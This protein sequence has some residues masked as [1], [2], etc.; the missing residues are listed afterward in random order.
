V[1]RALAAARHLQEEAPNAAPNRL[2]DILVQEGLLSPGD[3]ARALSEQERTGASLGRV[4]IG[5]GLVTEAGL[6]AALATQLGLEFVAVADTPLN[7]ALVALVPEPM[8]RRY[9]VIPVGEDE[10]GRLKVAMSDPSNILAL[11]DLR[12]VTDREVV[13]VVG[14]RSDILAAIDRYGGGTVEEADDLSQVLGGDEIDIG[15]AIND[16]IDDAPIVRFV[17]ALITRAVRDRAS[18]IHIEPQERDV[19]IRYRVDGVLHD[20]LSQPRKAHAGIASRLKIMADLDIAERRIPQDGRIALKLEG[21]SID[22]RVSTLPTVYGEKIVMRVLDK[23]SVL[24][25]LSDLGFMEHNYGRFEHSFRKPYGMILVTGPTGSGKST[26]LYATLNVINAPE[27]NIVTVE[28]PVEY[29][30]TGINQVQI[31]PKAGLTFPTAL[32]AI[33]R[34]DPDVVL[35]GEIRDRETAQIAMEAA[36]TGHLVLATLHTNDAPSTVTRLA[37]MGVDPFLIGSAVDCVLA[38]RLARRLC[39]LC[40]HA[41]QATPEELSSAGLPWAAGDDLP[42]L[43]RAVGC[44]SCAGTGYRGRLALHEVMQVSEEIERLVVARASVDDI[45]HLARSQGMHTLREDGLAKVLLGQTTLEEIARVV[46]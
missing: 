22:L 31:H 43:Y 27:V 19:R 3:L 20:I 4:L 9:G 10:R 28:D 2:G 35:V 15:E 34:Q 42:L 44:D 7:Q 36:M 18:D 24:L 25:E 14:I 11:D 6:V 39:K 21:K 26:T 8:A 29:R 37:E 41:Y 33:L 45:E 32:R 13:P 12:T 40:K 17:N 46:V 1:E 38:Q 16:V 5:L 30:L 23:S